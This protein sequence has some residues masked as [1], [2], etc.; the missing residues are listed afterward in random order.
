VQNTSAYSG[1]RK[2]ALK[3]ENTIENL[4]MDVK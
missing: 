2:A 3:R 1:G 4:V